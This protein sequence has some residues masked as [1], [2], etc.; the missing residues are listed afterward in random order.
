MVVPIRDPVGGVEW[1]TRIFVKHAPCQS[2][3]GGKLA[4]RRASRVTIRPTAVPIVLNQAEATV[5]HRVTST[6]PELSER[7]KS[8][9]ML[10]SSLWTRIRLRASFSGDDLG[11]HIARFPII[12]NEISLLADAI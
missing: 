8:Q 6:G 5:P 11:G 9:A 7:N 1:S 10:G 3:F 4:T 12:I 2:E